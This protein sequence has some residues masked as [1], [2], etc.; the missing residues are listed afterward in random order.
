MYN[1]GDVVVDGEA[2]FANGRASVS[3]TLHRKA[4]QLALD[5]ECNLFKL[6]HDV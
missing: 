2:Y 4:C 6:A 3:E 5:C 1:R